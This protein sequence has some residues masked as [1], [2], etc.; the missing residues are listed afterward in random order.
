VLL[1]GGSSSFAYL[2]TVSSAGLDQQ[3]VANVRVGSVDVGGM[4]VSEAVDAVSAA[5]VA[6]LDR[7]VKVT[8]QGKEFPITLRT[9]GAE[10]DVKGAV[11]D[12]VA[13]G[14]SDRVA[15]A[16]RET[17]ETLRATREIPLPVRLSPKTVAKALAPVA[18]ALRTAPVNAKAEIVGGQLQI[19]PHKVGVSPDIGATAEDV[20]Q[21]VTNHE[22]DTVGFRAKETPP[23]VKTEDLSGLEILSTFT[24]EFSTGQENR[25]GNIRLG[26]SFM[27]GTV[28]AAGGVFS[29]NQAIGRRT[30]DRGFEVAPV[31]SGNQVISGYGGGVCQIATT[32]YNTALE[33]G[34]KII[35]RHAHS[36]PVHYVPSG[37]D[38]TID[39]GSADLRFQ[40]TSPG[41]IIVRAAVNGGN[42]TISILGRKAAAPA[43][44]PPAAESAPPAAEVTR[45]MVMK[46]VP[47]REEPLTRGS[48]P[49]TTEKPASPPPTTASAS[50][51]H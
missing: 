41:A 40:N 3:I 47:K 37:R 17:V 16:L 12:A 43:A 10:I 35:E 31:Y 8:F 27:D 19:V 1:I 4:R 45:S 48:R 11:R 7:T 21:A 49:Y 13:V 33:A 22:A 20:C 42:L 25:A 28:V 32:T 2:A 36:L 34:M 29:A 38:A 30:P 51:T 6:E 9:L 14:K 5:A 39:Y 24:T 18:D 44:Q 50:A 46:A 23:E 15:T 26:C